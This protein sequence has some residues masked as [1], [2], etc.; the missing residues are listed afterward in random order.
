MEGI[1][2]VALD[3]GFD[4]AV[5]NARGQHVAVYFLGSLI[6]CRASDQGP[7]ESQRHH[8][9]F[10]HL[11]VSDLENKAVGAVSPRW[12]RRRAQLGCF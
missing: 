10:L 9:L 5:G 11:L 1:D 2:Q 4:D 7:R 3:L 6:E 8:D 12:R